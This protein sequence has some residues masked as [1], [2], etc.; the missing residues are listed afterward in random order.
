[1]D[2]Q[3][4]TRR[5]ALKL[6]AAVAGV[7]LAGSVSGILLGPRPVRASAARADGL[8]AA[9]AESD[10]IYVT[11]LHRDGRE[12]TCQAEVWFVADGTDAY[13]VT[14]SGAW[15]ERAVR[16]GLTGAR[17]WV[18]DVGVWKDSNG[19]YRELPRLE[20][21]AV[22]IDDPAEHARVLQIFGGKYSLEW[23]IWGPRFRRGLADGSRVM[24]RYRP[25]SETAPTA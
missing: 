3:R 15:R 21:E 2:E 11:P 22:Q 17:L 13:V 1:M 5:R 19:A 23:L 6:S 7:A 24:L 9:L 4:L 18:G 20:A 10:L 16:Q 8:Q 12:S 14:E 25:R